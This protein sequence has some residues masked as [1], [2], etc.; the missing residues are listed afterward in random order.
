MENEVIDVGNE[1]KVYAPDCDLPYF[2]RVEN[3]SL[4]TALFEETF[5]NDHDMN[6]IT[7]TVSSQ[8]FSYKFE[9]K[10]GEK[11]VVSPT[12][13]VP[14]NT[15]LAASVIKPNILHISYYP[16]DKKTRE[17]KR[18]VIELFLRDFDHACKWRDLLNNVLATGSKDKAPS[19]R[20]V[21][22]LLNPFSGTKKAPKVWNSAVLPIFMEAGLSYELMETA[23]AGHARD[24][25]RQCD[26]SKYDAIVTISGDGLL[27]EVVNGLMMRKD[28]AEAVK[29][30]ISVIPA[31]S[32]NALA[33]ASGLVEPVTAAF[34][35]ARGRAHPMDLAMIIQEKYRLSSFL[36]LA[37]G[38]VADV[39]FESEKYRWMGGARF[40]VT[41]LQRIASLRVYEGKFSYY[42][43][44]GFKMEEK[45]KCG[46]HCAHC[47]P[48]EYPGV[49][50]PSKS[51]TVVGWEDNGVS[52]DR[53]A[54]KPK[55]VFDGMEIDSLPKGPATPLID[56]LRAGDD[57]GW[58][59][60]E[61][62]GFILFL[63]S[64]VT[65]IASDMYNAPYAHL[66]DG[67]FDI[68]IAQNLSK[69]ALLSL[70]LKLEKGEHVPSDQVTYVKAKAYHLQPGQGSYLDVDGE[71]MP[72]N[73]PVYAEMSR[74]LLKFIKL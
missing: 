70:F 63:A 60:T 71:R 66:S 55:L 47:L 8:N 51:E 29:V 33:F 15:V 61:G 27:W 30:P 4:E 22:V 6:E 1:S 18:C 37:W 21:L 49:A 73:A 52:V 74:G 43:E 13:T 28:W 20:H 24:I 65:H 68:L 38:M 58:V 64:N 46:P 41:A 14:L 32:G 72:S 40:T 36:M 5:R 53:N 42:P 25:S 31:G 23:Y 69:T 9:S 2:F 39:D 3:S 12:R 45:A 7:L 62:K 10:K 11:K 57:E 59:H 56:A 54:R 19:R 44:K 26:L 50:D 16:L 17:R 67:C 48:V 35:V 34:S